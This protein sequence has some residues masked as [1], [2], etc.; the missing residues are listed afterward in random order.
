M[1]SHIK[2]TKTYK[3]SLPSIYNYAKLKDDCLNLKINA[4]D[5]PFNAQ[6][7]MQMHTFNSVVNFQHA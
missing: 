7:L 6:I 2:Y 1:Y 3:F 5:L 4:N